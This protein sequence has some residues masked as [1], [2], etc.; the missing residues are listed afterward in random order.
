MTGVSQLT[1]TAILHIV[2]RRFARNFQRKKPME[3]SLIVFVDWN[4]GMWVVQYR[5]SAGSMVT[6]VTGFPASTPSIVVCHKL[7][8]D[9]PASRVFAKLS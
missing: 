6:E 1:L 8:Q 2:S 9:R 7:L 4:Q 5:D 3:T